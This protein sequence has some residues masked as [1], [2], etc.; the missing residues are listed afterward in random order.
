[1]A[2]RE[3]LVHP[4]RQHIV[5]RTLYFLSLL[6][7]ISIA[8]LIVKRQLG[9]EYV[10]LLC[11]NPAG[12]QLAVADGRKICSVSDDSKL[13]WCTSYESGYPIAMEWRTADG[14]LAVLDREGG[15]SILDGQHG[16][17][18]SHLHIGTFVSGTLSPDGCLAVVLRTTEQ[19]LEVIETDDAS[20]I[21]YLELPDNLPLVAHGSAVVACSASAQR[22]AVAA[23]NALCVWN[24]EATDKLATVAILGAPATCL[25]FSQD[26][27]YV[28]AGLAN[29]SI[30]SY[31]F[32]SERVV[33][34]GGF[35]LGLI[36]ALRV[37]ESSNSVVA[38]TIQG[39]VLRWNVQSEKWEVLRMGK[40][41]L[42]VLALCLSNDES[43]LAIGTGY[44][45]KAYPRPR[46]QLTKLHLD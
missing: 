18:L 13:Q 39:D 31:D 26:R 34:S 30:A 27:S 23:D 35:N 4:E 21:K 32:D 6:L 12:S 37:L 40:D 19:R 1:M 7:G 42:S 44:V 5:A 11:W 17:E 10:H 24:L 25:Y 9:Y 41:S 2:V 46:G 33:E 29:G 20:H 15:L 43:T 38:G 45:E 14:N 22:V 28:Y 8:I 36:T 3:F 16:N